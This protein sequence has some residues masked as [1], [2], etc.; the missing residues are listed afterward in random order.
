[1]AALGL[2]AV[3][4]V[5]ATN[6]ATP[7]LKLRWNPISETVA[8]TRLVRRKEALLNSIMGISWYWYFAA[9]VLAQLPNFTRH[10]LHS[11]ESVLTLLLAVFAIS[12][13]VGSLL[14]ER[15]SRGDI[16][17][18][19]VPLG[20]IGMT[21]FV[22]DLFF[23]RYGTPP[24]QLLTVSEL[25]AGEARA[26]HLRV[27][28]DLAMAGVFSS[29]FIVPL[30]ALVQNRSD[31][32]SRSRVIA[33]NNIYNAVFMVVSALVT[34][35]LFRL[36]LT[37]LEILL[38]T[39][40]LNAVVSI[41]IFTLIP[42]FVLR[43]VLWVL[44]SLI[45]RLRYTGRESIPGRGAAV[46]VANHVSFIDWFIVT[47]ACRRPVRFVMDHT[48]FRMPL[49]GWLFRVAKAI[50]IAPAKQDAALK[51]KAFE[52]IS[53]ELQDG[54][55][56]CIFPEGAI[57]RDGAMA[58]FRPGIERILARDAVPVIPMALG[59]LWGSFFSRRAGRALHT[60]PRPRR[61]IIRI[62]VGAPLSPTTTAAELQGRVAALLAR[63]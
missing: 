14:C 29:V 41:Y 52:Q 61:R 48:F 12:I 42:E 59:G 57:T 53:R 51:E 50:P 40:I 58:P 55:L 22:A 17:L 16:E 39:A 11:D 32:E 60:L 26:A 15:L 24:A 25:F 36:H 1:V 3:H 4:F 28:C 6:L 23:V 63:A 21:V 62:D 18:G 33:A 19:L 10:M 8:L 20:S 56:V 9:T 47:A 13:G 54:N 49:L 34:M 2:A 31:P 46:I 38:V 43:F 30:Y 35:I 44:A 7:S 5:P 37:T 27:L 45:Y